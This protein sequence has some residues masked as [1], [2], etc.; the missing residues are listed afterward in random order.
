M[1]TNMYYLWGLRKVRDHFNWKNLQISWHCLKR[2]EG[3]MLDSYFQICIKIW[4]FIKEG[5]GTA[6]FVMFVLFNILTDNMPAR[7][8]ASFNFLNSVQYILIKVNFTYLCQ[9]I[10][11]NLQSLSLFYCFSKKVLHSWFCHI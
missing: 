9:C 11:A 4:H 2:R 8:V 7:V 1:S 10:T 5:G 6:N 3:V